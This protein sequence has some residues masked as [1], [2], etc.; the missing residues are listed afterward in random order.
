MARLDGKK[1]STV[2]L[3]IGLAALALVVGGFFLMQNRGADSVTIQPGDVTVVDNKSGNMVSNG[4]DAQRDG[5]SVTIG[6]ETATGETAAA[7]DVNANDASANSTRDSTSNLTGDSTGDSTTNPTGDSTAMP[8]ATVSSGSD[9]PDTDNSTDKSM[10]STKDASP[11]EGTASA[12]T[13][14]TAKGSGEKSDDK[15]DV[16]RERSKTIKNNKTG[17]TVTYSKKVHGDGAVTHEKVTS[18]AAT[19]TASR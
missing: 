14:S 17:T 9:E 11:G 8:P 18:P 10:D 5:N 7:A 2:P 13:A 4:I 19:P 1:K 3:F 16:G 15:K 12:A 6:S